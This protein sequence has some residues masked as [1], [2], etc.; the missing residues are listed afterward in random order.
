[1]T[2][3]KTEPEEKVGAAKIVQTLDVVAADRPIA[4]PAEGAVIPTRQVTVKPEVQ[5]LV[6]RHH[7]A[8]VA[9]GFVGEGEEIVGIDRSNYELALEEHQAA[10]EEAQF[11]VS[12]EEGR[13][14]V[15]KREFG[16]LE[17]DLDDDEVNK[18]L[19]LREPHLAKAKALVAKAENLIAK[20]EL[21]L[22]RTAL[23]AP[24]NAVVIEESIEVGQLV[25]SGD[26]ICT[27][28]GTDAFW[29][30]VTV[31][32]EDLKWIRLGE[33]DQPGSKAIV[34]LD[35]GNGESVSWAG[36][37]ERLLGDL[38]PTSRMARLVVRVNDPLGRDSGDDEP[39]KLPL[40]LGSFVEV[41]IEAGVLENVIEIPRS[42]LRDGDNLWVVDEEDELQIRAT[43]VMW[44]QGESL[45]VAN[46]IGEGEE[47][48]VS[49]L[50]AALPGMK[51]NPQPAPARNGDGKG[52]RPDGP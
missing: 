28:V 2:A 45:L 20:A 19:V 10:L 42:A 47:L 4:V 39:T 48:I 46:T 26:T 40:L 44:T 11:E 23:T 6:V 29:V 51:V 35:T 1:M 3:P 9:G 34:F 52:G 36:E 8:L 5:G 32:F 38:H 13:Q 12:V 22:E 33:G 27:L 7:P 43:E 17:K 41:K 24:F 30:E 15:A 50:R 14:V 37:V 31:P 16:L 49:D 25:E 21:D 18:S